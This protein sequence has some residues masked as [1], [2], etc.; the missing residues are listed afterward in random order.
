M[1]EPAQ[2]ATTSA[3]QKVL[4]ITG[5]TSGI[6]LATVHLFLRQGWR[7]LMHGRRTDAL[8]YALLSLRRCL[9]AHVVEQNLRWHLCDLQTDA[10]AQALIDA[11]LNHFGRIDA[12]VANAG[13]SHRSLFLKTHK[14]VLE[15]V[16]RV[17]FWGAVYC[18]QAAL[19]HLM[20]THGVIVGISSLAGCIGLPARTLYS[21]SKFALE[22]FLEALR[23]EVLP[24]GVHVAIVR[25]GFVATPIRQ[26]ALTETGAPQKTSPLDEQK[27]LPPERVARAIWQVVHRRKK[28]VVTVARPAERLALWLNRLNT[29]W[30]DQLLWRKF[31]REPHSPLTQ[32][33]SA[34][35]H[36]ITQS[37]LE[38]LR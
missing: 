4:L 5:A 36:A 14:E 16:M 23:R 2:P 11:T 25:P 15:Q 17:N 6:G 8:Q 27:A 26:K 35:H 38:R 37:G 33:R 30:L 9:P 7:V 29:P 20:A 19:P 24:T 12:L 22:G 10:C 18:I 21:A 3:S 32:I 34:H 31:A 1:A 28:K 13:I